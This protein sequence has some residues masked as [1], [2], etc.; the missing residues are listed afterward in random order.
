MISFQRH[1]TKYGN[2][3]AEWD[4]ASRSDAQQLLASVMSSEFI[5][6]F[7]TLYQY[8]SQFAGITVKVQKKSSRYCQSK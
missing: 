1:I 2:T 5:V 6:I 8:L 4:P 7:M 3:F